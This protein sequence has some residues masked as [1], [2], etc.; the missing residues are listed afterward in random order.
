VEGRTPEELARDRSLS[1]PA[2]VSLAGEVRFSAD[3]LLY[4]PYRLADVTGRLVLG[5]NR[6]ELEEVRFRAYGG[7]GSARGWAE[8][9]GGEPRPFRLDLN[10]EDV[11]AEEYF[12]QNTPLGRVIGG[13]LTMKAAVRGRL[14]TL[15]LPVGVDLA[16]DGR[17]DLLNG[18]LAP[19]AIIGS[20]GPFLRIGEPSGSGRDAASDLRFSR[21]TLPF[22][23]RDG[24]LQL[25]GGA[26]ETDDLK[27]EMAGAVGFGGDLQMDVLARLDTA[28]AR[29]IAESGGAAARIMSAYLAAGIPPRLGLVVTGN[30][31]APQVAVD[32]SWLESAT[33][34]LASGAAGEAGRTGLD[35]IE[36]RGRDLLRGLLGGEAPDT[37]SAPPDTAA[38]P[39]DTTDA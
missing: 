24:A 11:R 12:A 32:R 18:R 2:R 25:S 21:W 23:I 33:R 16:G 1:R 6:I 39:A 27:L 20:L 30:A 31:L 38:S 29:S 19:N 26:L 37:V 8:L 5:A 22:Q 34:D 9:G 3:S 7:S 15:L 4:S 28:T 13:N 17:L 35:E 10:L 14:D 36:R